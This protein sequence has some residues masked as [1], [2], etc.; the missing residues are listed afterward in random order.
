M[1]GGQYQGSSIGKH[2]DINLNV[3]HTIWFE[4]EPMF[5]SYHCGGPLY[6]GSPYRGTIRQALWVHPLMLAVQI[7]TVKISKW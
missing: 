1:V 6:K 5:T 4:E 2:S 3:L 7:L